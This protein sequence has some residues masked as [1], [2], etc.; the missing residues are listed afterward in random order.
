[1]TLYNA[2]YK[3]WSGRA[4]TQV[5]FGMITVRAPSSGA[6]HMKALD[7][8]RRRVQADKY[9]RINVEILSVEAVEEEGD[10]DR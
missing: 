4:D 2:E 3:T 8:V 1:M 9:P 6:A 7:E 5:R 10:A